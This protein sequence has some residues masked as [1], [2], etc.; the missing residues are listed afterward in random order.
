MKHRMSETFSDARFRHQLE[1]T[2]QSLYS[3]LE[4]QPHTCK[5][6]EYIWLD[7]VIFKNVIGRNQESQKLGAHGFGPL[8]ILNLIGKNAVRLS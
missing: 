6:G 7:I 2:I 4:T 1:K 5:E 3:E 8:T